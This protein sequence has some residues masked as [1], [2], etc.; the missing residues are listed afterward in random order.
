MGDYKGDCR[1]KGDNTCGDEALKILPED[2]SMKEEHHR[3]KMV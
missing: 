1:E 2:S 3:K